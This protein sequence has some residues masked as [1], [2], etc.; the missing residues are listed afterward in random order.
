MEHQRILNLL[1]QASSSKFVIRKPNI[2]NDQ[3]NKNYDFGSET[4]HNAV[5]LKSNLCNYR[6]AYIFVRGDIGI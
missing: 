2:I 4:L 1:N 6:D 3:S 5:V